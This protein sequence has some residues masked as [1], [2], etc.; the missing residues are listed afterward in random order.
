MNDIEM[1]MNEYVERL[2]FNAT[3]HERQLKKALEQRGVEFV[4]QHAVIGKKCY[5]LDFYFERSDG[6]K[7]AVELDGLQHYKKKGKKYDKKRDSYLLTTYSIKVF[8]FKNHRNKSEL[9]IIV[10]K[11]IATNPKRISSY[12]LDELDMV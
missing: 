5:I 3:I 10:D 9:N 11:I 1:V 4:F 7:F 8:R 12:D 6:R 2:I